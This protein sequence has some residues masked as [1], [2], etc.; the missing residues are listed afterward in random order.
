MKLPITLIL[1]YL[2]ASMALFTLNRQEKNDKTM[3]LNEKLTELEG[4]IKY[5]DCVDPKISKVAL[6]WHLDHSLRT[7]NEICKALK[8]SDSENYR[9]DINLGRSYLL[10]VNKIPRGQAQAPKIVVPSDTIYTDSLYLQLDKARANL[11]GYD[12]LPQKAFF[13]HPYL[14]RLKKRTAKRF[15]E[16]HTEHHLK[17]IRDILKE[18][19]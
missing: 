2:V 15:I 14:G 16:I 5:R 6:D 11:V 18:Q 4:Y 1:V 13:T 3:F 19:S 9:A 10:L 12:S 17:I 8:N 7:V